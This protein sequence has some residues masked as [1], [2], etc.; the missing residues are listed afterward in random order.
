MLREIKN[1]RQIEGELP[2]RWFNDK[3]MDLI[4]WIDENREIAGFQ[5]TY[6]KHH[7][8]HALT[9]TRD[10]GFSHKQVDDGEGRPG[11]Y[12]A[13]PLLMPDGKFDAQTTASKFLKNS[14]E[15]DQHISRFVH[16]KLLSFSDNESDT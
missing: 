6:D 13:T 3:E 4:V 1:T 14:C 12:K 8:E 9:W 16:D 5:L 2:R 11:K 15:I 7:F 10:N